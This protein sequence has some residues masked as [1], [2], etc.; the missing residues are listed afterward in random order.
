M[1]NRGSPRRQIQESIYHSLCEGGNPRHMTAIPMDKPFKT[2]LVTV[3]PK[4][5][6]GGKERRTIQRRKLLKPLKDDHFKVRPTLSKAYTTLD[7]ARVN[8]LPKTMRNGHLY[9][10]TTGTEIS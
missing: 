3:T 5:P 7:L 9:L 2:N 1:D 6:Y 10:L 8:T 4:D